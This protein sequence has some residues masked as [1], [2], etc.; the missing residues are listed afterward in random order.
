MRLGMRKLENAFHSYIQLLNRFVRK[1]LRALL[2]IYWHTILCLYWHTI[3][4]LYWHTIL[5]LY[6]HI[7][8]CLYW[9]TILCLYWHTI[10]CL[11]WHTILC[12]Y[13][14]T[15]LCLYWHTIFCLY[16]HTMP[17]L[18]ALSVLQITTIKIIV[19]HFYYYFSPQTQTRKENIQTN[20]C[21]FYFFFIRL[22]N[23]KG[24][25][26]KSFIACYIKP[27]DQW[28]CIAHL[29]PSPELNYTY[30]CLTM[31]RVTRLTSVKWANLITNKFNST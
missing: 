30:G 24:E 9:Q 21:F 16:W 19:A 27:G 28:P 5:C 29:R 3:F 7:I 12:F 31:K 26:N 25:N 8:L 22:L 15:I 23:P 11:Y 17:I 20:V 1:T 6:W 14:H 4:C 13:W 2:S 18:P 10:L